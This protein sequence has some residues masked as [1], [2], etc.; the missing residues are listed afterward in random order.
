MLAGG[1]AAVGAMQVAK[2]P[3]NVG[4]RAAVEKIVRDY[5]LAN[6]EVLTQAMQNLEARERSKAVVSNRKALETPF[7]AAWQGA[8][9]AD[10]TLVQFFDYACG[11]CRAS[12]P[13]IERLLAED[14]NLRVVYR[15][16]PVLGPESEL[17]A[18]TSLAIAQGGPYAEFHKSLYALGRP[19]EKSVATA[20]RAL[21]LDPDTL[22]AAGKGP[23]VT[24][25][26]MKNFELQRAI[27]IGGTPGWVVGDRVLDGAVGYDKLKE[28][29]AEARAAR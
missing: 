13:D 1:A 5:I 14:K 22:K 7:G 26:L 19:G 2:D 23:A 18:R 24:G 27:G 8:A 10:V 4:D 20:A 17:A 9:N 29:I 3:V 15:E 28:A 25:E 11:F 21:K 12:L 16:L 6:P